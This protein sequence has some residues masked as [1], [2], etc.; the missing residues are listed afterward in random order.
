MESKI[1]PALVVLVIIL[2]ILAMGLWTWGSGQAKAI[3]GP[4]ELLTDPSGHVYI[5][6]QNQLLEHDDAGRF[7]ERHDLGKLDVERVLGAI[8]FFS[9]GDMLLRRGADSRTL[10][11]NLRAFFRRTN[12]KSLT[13]D[14]SGEGLYRCNLRTSECAVFGQEA[15]DFKAAFGLFIDRRSDAVYI[16]DTTRHVLRK[17]SADGEAVAGPAAGFRFP[18]QILLHDGLLLVADTNHHRIRAVDP[19]TDAFAEEL[20]SFDVVPDDARRAKRTWPSHFTHV[21]DMWWVNNMRTG[22]NEGAIY[23]FDDDWHYRRKVALPSGADPIALLPLLGEVLISD[24]NND[25]VH[26]VSAAGELL[27]DFQSPG[28][29][30]VIS[31]S[32]QARGQFQ[33]VAYLGVAVFVLL[34]AVLLVKSLTTGLSITPAGKHVSA[35]ELPT[36]TNRHSRRM[37]LLLVLVAIAVAIVWI[38]VR[39]AI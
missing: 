39:H 5:Q 28:L 26:R 31:E 37:Q 32:A 18:N 6:I 24:W 3:G 12:V 2:V 17:Y 30:Q 19:T 13:P 9:N 29:A 1:H 8:G 16:S 33:A 7:V 25:R 38:M 35:A 15:I 23:I 10:R 11:D 22:M 14:S 4:A 27:G 20:A 34:I 36:G 21:G